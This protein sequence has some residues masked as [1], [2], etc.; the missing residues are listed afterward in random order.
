V[1][2]DNL[3]ARERAQRAIGKAASAL[4]LKLEQ[5]AVSGR[6]MILVCRQ[7]LDLWIEGGGASLDDEVIGILGIDSQ[8]DHVMLP[9]DTRKPRFSAYDDEEAE[10]ESLGEFFLPSFTREMRELADR[11]NDS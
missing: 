3:L 4:C 5:D 6:D 11:F 1:F 10:I 2:I 7:I 8:C 9:P